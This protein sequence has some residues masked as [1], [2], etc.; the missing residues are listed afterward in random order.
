MADVGRNI[1]YGTIVKVS[2]VTTTTSS[3]GASAVGALLDVGGFTNAVPSVDVTNIAD[4][5]ACFAPGTPAAGP[6]SLTV[7]YKDTDTGCD[8]L[9]AM[10]AG[11]TKGIVWIVYASTDLADEKIKG[12]VSDAGLGTIAKDSHITR[13]F[14]VQPTSAIGW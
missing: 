2:T 4:A 12:F 7:G 11:R 1:G 8:K 10:N 9:I 3:T 13:T 5:A 14:S 6:G